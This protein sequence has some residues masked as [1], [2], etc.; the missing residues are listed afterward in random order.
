VLDPSMTIEM[1]ISMRHW[2]VNDDSRNVESS[3]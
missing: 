2:L 1:K 3:T